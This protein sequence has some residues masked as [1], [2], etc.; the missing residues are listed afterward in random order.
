MVLIAAMLRGMVVAVSNIVVPLKRQ[1]LRRH[2]GQKHPNVVQ[3]TEERGG[4]L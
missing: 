1:P 4:R 2:V 3:I